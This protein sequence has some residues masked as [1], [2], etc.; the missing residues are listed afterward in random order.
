M[1]QADALALLQAGGVL[2]FAGLV[3]FEL[4]LLRPILASLRDQNAAI[5]EWIRM[6]RTPPHGVPIMRLPTDGQ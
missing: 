2:A 1:G 3:W 6:S 5:L 4:R